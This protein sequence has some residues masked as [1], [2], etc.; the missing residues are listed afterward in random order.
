MPVNC[1]VKI[2]YIGIYIL[3][4][5]LSQFQWPYQGGSVIRYR[6]HDGWVGV[7]RFFCKKVPGTILG[8]SF[9]N[10]RSTGYFLGRYIFQTR[11]TLYAFGVSTKQNWAIFMPRLYLYT[12]NLN[13]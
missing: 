10:M 6:H 2:S 5:N 11:S 7:F 3:I 1:Y 12:Q 9:W 8:G 13:I 4:Y